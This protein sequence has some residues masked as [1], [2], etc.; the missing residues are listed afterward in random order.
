MLLPSEV[1]MHHDADDVN[2]EIFV[3]HTLS[4]SSES[5]Y[6]MAVDVHNYYLTCISKS[7]FFFTFFGK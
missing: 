5:A 6:F 4:T 7:P 2:S 3:T 1:F